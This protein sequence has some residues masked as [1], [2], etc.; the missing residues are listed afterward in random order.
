MEEREIDM[1]LQPEPLYEVEHILK[2]RK[3]RVGRRSSREFLVTWR[4]HPLDEAQWIL[5]ANFTSLYNS[6][7]PCRD[8]TAT[9]STDVITY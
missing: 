7:A 2:W 3:V 6:F 4:G 8:R 5:E 9:S 1:D